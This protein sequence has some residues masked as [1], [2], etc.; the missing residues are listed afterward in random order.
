MEYRDTMNRLITDFR[1]DYGNQSQEYE[2]KIQTLNKQLQN[3][4]LDSAS[5]ARGN[6]PSRPEMSSPIQ[7]HQIKN[8]A[9]P[10]SRPSSSKPNLKRQ[11]IEPEPPRSTYTTPKP[12]LQVRQNP[13]NRP[14]NK[15]PNTAPSQPKVQFKEP[16]SEEDD[17]EPQ[18]YPSPVVLKPKPSSSNKISAMRAREEEVEILLEKLE[19]LSLQLEKSEAA[20]MDLRQINH[21]LQEELDLA[22]VT[23][24]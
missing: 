13:T 7:Q 18:G 17:D 14:L 24:T 11:D 23:S 19:E 12:V 21:R 1:S 6:T 8:T 4:A 9:K 5:P 10:S 15:I 22:Q 2:H 16:E 20:E 3:L